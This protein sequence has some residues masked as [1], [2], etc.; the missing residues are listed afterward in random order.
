MESQKSKKKVP[1]E[2]EGIDEKLLKRFTE[3]PEIFFSQLPP[4]GADLTVKA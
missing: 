4:I 2:L 1:K 3:D